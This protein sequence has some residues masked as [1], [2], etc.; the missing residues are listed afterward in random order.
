[1]GAAPIG[2]PGCP[3]LDFSMASTAKKRIELIQSS[4]RDW[5]ATAIISNC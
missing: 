5:V 4:W 1:M 2:S 3:D